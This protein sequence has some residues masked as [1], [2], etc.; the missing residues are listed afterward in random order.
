M[1]SDIH[2]LLEADDSDTQLPLYEKLF[3]FFIA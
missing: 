2:S 1:H 3:L